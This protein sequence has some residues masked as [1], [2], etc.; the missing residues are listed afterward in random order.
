MAM[1]VMTNQP[2]SMPTKNCEAI[3]VTLDHSVTMEACNVSL[4]EY[5]SVS[6]LVPDKS[7]IVDYRQP[8]TKPD[9]DTF[10]TTIPQKIWKM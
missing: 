2:E 6:E 1:T 8:L 10:Q 5:M 9:V 3:G 7:S 4:S